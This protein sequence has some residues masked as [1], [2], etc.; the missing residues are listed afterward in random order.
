MLYV[1]LFLQQRG[2][3]KAASPHIL[4]SWLLQRLECE[5][6]H[7]HDENFLAFY[8]HDKCIFLLY[9]S[10]MMENTSLVMLYAAFFISTVPVYLSKSVGFYQGI[11]NWLRWIP[12]A[13][14]TPL[15]KVFSATWSIFKYGP[16]RPASGGGAHQPK[17]LP[18]HI[19]H[20]IAQEWK[21]F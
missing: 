13:L 20:R 10:R 8:C 5:I 9:F 2:K 1:A 11:V 7:L 3:R 6:L 15:P 12:H 16:V 14:H 17:N 21:S 19:S 18:S 4:L